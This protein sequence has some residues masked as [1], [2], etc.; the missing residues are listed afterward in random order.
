[1]TREPVTCPQDGRD[2]T[3][4]EILPGIDEQ[5]QYPR[6]RMQPIT[7]A[8][9]VRTKKLGM[10]GWECLV[11]GVAGGTFSRTVRDVSPSR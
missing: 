4:L 6:A 9:G 11:D 1:M 5:K 7:A 10:R 8:C 2:A 3:A